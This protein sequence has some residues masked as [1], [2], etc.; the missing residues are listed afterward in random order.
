M[1]NEELIRQQMEETRA[2]ITE[3]LE[4]L[5]TK[6]ADDIQAATGSVADT[7]KAVQETVSTVKD[8]VEGGAEAVKEVVQEVVQTVKSWFDLK[9]QVEERP[10]LVMAGAAGVGFCLGN[11]LGGSSRSTVSEIV[12]AAAS[13]S[14][15]KTQHN[16]NGASHSRRRS[17]KSITS[18]VMG[19][20]SSWLSDFSPQI[21]KLKGLAISTMLSSV[22][23]IVMQS[24]PAQASGVLNEI[25]DNVLQKLGGDKLP[26]P[27]PPSSFASSTS[28]EE[29][30]HSNQFD[31]PKMGRSMGS[32]RGQG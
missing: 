15:T 1:E 7:V 20:A 4:T 26:D 28:G 8:S 25:L 18:S 11:M 10:W 9:G 13:P 23:D 16:G 31:G 27:P 22:R 29:H 14:P 32:A 5:E 21:A 24:V 6:V 17:E 30:E 3:K 2:S 12:S 19:T